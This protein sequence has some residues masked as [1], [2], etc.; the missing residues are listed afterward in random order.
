MFVI[1]KIKHSVETPTALNLPVMPTL[2]SAI[3]AVVG[4][5]ALPLTVFGGI[6]SLCS[7]HIP[8]VYAVLSHAASEA[9]HHAAC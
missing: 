1:F 5:Q 6:R 9:A 8:S 2:N 7:A 4:L 3:P